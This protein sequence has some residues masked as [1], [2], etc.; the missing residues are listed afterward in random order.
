M[1][2]RIFLEHMASGTA[3]GARDI[4]EEIE[5]VGGRPTPRPSTRPPIT[6]VLRKDSPRVDI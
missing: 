4:A 1:A 3:A 2:S 5:A 6:R